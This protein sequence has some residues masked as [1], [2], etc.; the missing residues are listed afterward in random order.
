MCFGCLCIGHRSK[1]CWKRLSCEVCSLKHPSILHIHP[2]E[3]LTDS[4]RAKRESG[5]AVGS[6]LNSVQTSGFTAACE[7]D[8]TLSVV[9]AQVKSKK[10]HEPLVTYAFLDP[11]ST[12]SFCTERLMNKLN[13]RGGKTGIILRTM[14][15]EK[16]V[17][18]TLFQVWRWVQ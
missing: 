8:C 17:K 7:Y 3:K 13:L 1:D 18:A 12:A 11:G 16:I 6:A 9:P 2:K 4:V 10:G 5:P 14:G 15:Q